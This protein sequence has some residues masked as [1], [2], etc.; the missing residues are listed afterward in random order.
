MP[1]DFEFTNIETVVAVLGPLSV[2]TV[3]PSGKKWVNISAVQPLLNNILDDLLMSSDDDTG[4]AKELKVAISSDLRPRYSESEVSVLLDKC[5]FLDPRFCCKCLD[6]FEG[7]K[8][9][10]ADEGVTVL[11]NTTTDSSPSTSTSS[12]SIVAHIEEC[13]PAVPKKRMEKAWVLF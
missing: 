2:F 1:S 8:N 11:M 13:Q 10:I 6:D 7:T 5:S 4:F 3:A 12:G 9:N